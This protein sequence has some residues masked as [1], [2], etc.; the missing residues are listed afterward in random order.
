MAGSSREADRIAGGEEHDGQHGIHGWPSRQGCRAPAQ[1]GGVEG[2][3]RHVPG[4][5]TLHARK[6]AKGQ[7]VHGEIGAIVPEELHHARRIADAKL[8]HHDAVAPGN[9][10][11]SQFMDEH[12]DAEDN[13]KR[14]DSQQHV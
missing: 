9:Q 2:T 5:F 10:V 7:Q 8:F 3:R 6:A 4:I 1:A 14:Q 13:N 11:M 12:Q